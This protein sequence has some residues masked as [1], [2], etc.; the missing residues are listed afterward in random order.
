MLGIYTN[1]DRFY[2]YI[3]M[4]NSRILRSIQ[5]NSNNIKIIRQ[6]KRDLF[7]HTLNHLIVGCGFPTVIHGNTNRSRSL[8]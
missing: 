8:I 7:S 6:M 1:H 4:L 5:R 2:Q 3:L